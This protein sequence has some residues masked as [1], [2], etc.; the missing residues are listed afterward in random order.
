MI[1]CKKC[2]VHS[3]LIIGIESSWS[4]ECFFVLNRF[5]HFFAPWLLVSII[6]ILLRLIAIITIFLKEKK[7][8]I[9]MQIVTETGDLLFQ[10]LQDL[11]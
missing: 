11:G 3:L 10:I 4:A 1:N 9:F 8:P 2:T 5:L 6:K 7:F